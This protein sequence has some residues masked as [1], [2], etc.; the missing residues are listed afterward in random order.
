[1]MIG[2]DW[3]EEEAWYEED[4][5]YDC[6][7]EV[8]ED[9]AGDRPRGYASAIPMVQ[10][11]IAGGEGTDGALRIGMESAKALEKAAVQSWE[12]DYDIIL[13]NM[14]KV[15]Q[16]VSQCNSSSGAKAYKSKKLSWNAKS[17]TVDGADAVLEA[18]E[19]GG[20]SHLLRAVEKDMKEI[21]ML[22]QKLL[23]T[24]KQWEF[25]RF[26]SFRKRWFTLVVNS[27]QGYQLMKI[28]HLP[29]IPHLEMP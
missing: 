8:E 16:V 15:N 23:Q 7:K 12:V 4:E 18:L 14:P 24:R 17:T 13:D 20:L 19:K 3:Y 25:T 2:N 1:M 11:M 21:V 9:D 29:G 26:K 5:W 28:V 22:Q 10:V 6:A 27:P